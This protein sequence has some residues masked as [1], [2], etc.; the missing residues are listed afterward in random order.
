MYI[1]RVYVD[2]KLT[3]TITSNDKS[4]MMERY[5]S[6]AETT[7]RFTFDF[8]YDTKVELYENDKRINYVE[9]EF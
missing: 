2:H 8:G 5:K 9:T 6:L 4:L 7:E 1:I 3:K